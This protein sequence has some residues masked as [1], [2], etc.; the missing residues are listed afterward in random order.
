ML[1]K[2]KKKDF[3][4]PVKKD[5]KVDDEEFKNAENL[6]NKKTTRKNKKK[7]KKNDEK[8]ADEEN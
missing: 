2:P 5:R 1:H 4:A 7:D 3:S 8:K 6:L